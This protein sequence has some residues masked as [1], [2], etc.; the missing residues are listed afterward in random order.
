MKLMDDGLLCLIPYTHEDDLDMYAC[1][2]DLDTQKGYNGIFTES[3]EQFQKFDIARFLF[4]V[5]V[6]NTKTGEKIGTLRLGL[7]GTCPDL[8]IWIY[9]QYRNQGY[10]TR[11]F[12]LALKYLFDHFPYQ[13]ISAGCYMRNDASRKMLEKIGFDRRPDL[14]VIEEDCF[15]GGSITQMEYRISKKAFE[16]ANRL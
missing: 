6:I 3:F 4:W 16:D 1:W 13:E 12:R 14:D 11:S 7:D 9:P 2:Q 15:T 10:G 8:A 5:T